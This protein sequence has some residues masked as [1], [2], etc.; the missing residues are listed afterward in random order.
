MIK[1]E[2]LRK[3]GKLIRIMNGRL[4]DLPT[5]INITMWWNFGSLLGLVLSIQILTGMFLAMHYTADINLAFSSVSH[6]V[7]DVNGGWFLRTL[8]ANGASFFFICLYAHVGRGL[9]YGRYGSK[10]L[11]ASGVLLLLL[12]M[13]S[14]FLGYVLPWG[15]IRFWG[16]TVIT[17]L[18]RAVPSCGDTL[19]AWLWGGFSVG[20]ATLTRFFAF[21][22]IVPLL[23][24]GVVFLHICLLHSSGR[25]NPLGLNSSTDKIPFHWYFTIKD[26]MGFVVLLTGLLL[27]VFFYPNYLGEPDNFIDANPLSTPAHI[28]PEWYFLF[29]Y[30]ILRSVPN[31]LGG[32][33]G[34]VG[35]LLF[36][37]VLPFIDRFSF[38]GNTFYPLRKALHWT[39]F[40]SFLILTVGGAW[41][42]EEPFTT[43]ARVFSLLYF[44]FFI[45][46]LPLRK[47][48]DRLVLHY[49]RDFWRYFPR[50]TPRDIT[51]IGSF[52]WRS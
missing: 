11:W 24:A 32:V 26:L 22:F 4:V 40:L 20:N 42:V 28:V 39:F 6:I 33:V 15:Q 49:V 16:A 47:L 50:R 46:H 30:A 27:L 13:A 23:V 36:L 1:I 51:S 25:N 37:L 43:T 38:K 8:H 44:S 19:V 12:V 2:R 31:K 14:A 48:N 10:S 21:H 35:S 29:A 3:S 7:R 45:L 41:P 34:L 18:L 9:Y 5:P 17:N 52:C